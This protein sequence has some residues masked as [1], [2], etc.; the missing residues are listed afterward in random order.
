MN[1]NEIEI[2]RKLKSYFLTK[3]KIKY[4]GLN[5]V[6]SID[7]VNFVDECLQMFSQNDRKFII[8]VYILDK[9]YDEI[10]YSKSNFYHKKMCYNN[11][12]LAILNDLKW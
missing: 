10:N 5:D 4:L 9:H 8:D 1:C 6:Q 12:L 7:K 2:R 11:T 3:N